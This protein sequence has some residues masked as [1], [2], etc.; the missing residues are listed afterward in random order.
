[1]KAYKWTMILHSKPIVSKSYFYNNKYLFLI[2]L[3]INNFF[4]RKQY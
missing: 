2:F 3:K 4:F 1:M